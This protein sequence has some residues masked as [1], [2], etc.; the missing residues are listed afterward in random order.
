MKK[1]EER[2]REKEKEAVSEAIWP[3]VLRPASTHQHLCA[4]TSQCNRYQ[5]SP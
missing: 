4:S 3:F 1:E 2:E 5:T